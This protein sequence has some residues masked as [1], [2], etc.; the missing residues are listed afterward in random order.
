[1]RVD[2]ELD[3]DPGHLKDGTILSE[4]IRDGTIKSQDIKD[5]EIRDVDLSENSV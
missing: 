2:G 5:G 3:I 4:D 1:M